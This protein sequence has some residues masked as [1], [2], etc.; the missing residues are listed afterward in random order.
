[1]QGLGAKHARMPIARHIHPE[2]FEIFREASVSTVVE[3]FLFERGNF[4]RDSE[5]KPAM[6]KTWTKFFLYITKSIQHG[7]DTERQ[8]LQK[9]TMM[10]SIVRGRGKVFLIVGMLVF[11]LVVIVLILFFGDVSIAE[12]STQTTSSETLTSTETFSVNN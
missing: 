6:E 3:L 1:M 9:R 11:T 10:E 8:A 4:T 5:M 12:H 7:F 2:Y